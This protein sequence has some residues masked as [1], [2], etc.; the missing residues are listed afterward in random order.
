MPCTFSGHQNS[1]FKLKDSGMLKVKLDLF[2][3]NPII[4]LKKLGL[5]M[6]SK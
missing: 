4:Q 5:E 1:G 3:H 2:H 6:M